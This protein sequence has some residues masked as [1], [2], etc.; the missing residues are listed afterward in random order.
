MKRGYLAVT[1]VLNAVI[2]LALAV[3]VLAAVSVAGQ[4]PTETGTAR[5]GAASGLKT[6]WGA[7]DLQGIWGKADEVPLQ[8]PTKFADKEFFTD[9]ERVELDTQR[10]GA[11]FSSATD[12]RRS[13]GQATDVN[14]AYNAEIF[15]THL[16]LGRRTSLIVDPPDGRVPPRTAAAQKRRATVRAFQL[17]LLAPT[18]ACKDKLRACA[19]GTYGPP[20]PLRNQ[21]PPAYIS[22]MNRADNPEDRSLGERCLGGFESVPNFGSGSFPFFPRIVQSADAVSIYLDVGQGNGYVRVIPITNAPH[23]PPNVR[24]W[25]GDSRGRW[26]GDTLVVDVTNFGPKL[27]YQG[28]TQD[29]HVVERYR[30]IDANTL[31]YAA[32]VEDPATWTRPWTATQEWTKQDNQM[33]RHYIEPR[34]HEGNY[35]IAGLLIGGRADD[36]A[37]AEGRGP[38]PATLF[39]T[40]GGFAAGFDD[41]GE[42]SNPLR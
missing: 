23:L 36:K 12:A 24:Q 39:T 37:F 29:L 6:S 5:V 26:E 8:R 32:T 27:A 20:S 42:D 31:E 1:P 33:N 15:T 38:D 21:T 11:I 35:G 10:T 19:G 17:A 34:C 13:R 7:P 4:A 40:Y 18:A 30:R 14:G 41:E 22:G 3:I 25:W 16:R 28:A 2:V 9:A